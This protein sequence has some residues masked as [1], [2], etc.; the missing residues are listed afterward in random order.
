M[1]KIHID[2][3]M[4]L[5]SS[6][7]DNNELNSIDDLM[8]RSETSEENTLIVVQEYMGELLTL[9]DSENEEVNV[10]VISTFGI[11]ARIGMIKENEEINESFKRRKISL[12]IKRTQ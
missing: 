2:K 7:D 10:Q 6:L 1:V 4:N 8:L 5:I 9:L 12:K 11:A 3:V